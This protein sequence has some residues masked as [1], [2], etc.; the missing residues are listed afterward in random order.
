MSDHGLMINRLIPSSLR[1]AVG[2]SC[3]GV[4]PATLQM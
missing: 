3:A 1:S 4:E 2:R